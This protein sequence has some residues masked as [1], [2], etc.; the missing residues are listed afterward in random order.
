MA[1]GK[2][3]EMIREGMGHALAVPDTRNGTARSEMR[4]KMKMIVSPSCPRWGPGRILAGTFSR[5][6]GG[7]S[8]LARTP[9]PPLLAP[10]HR[11]VLLKGKVHC[12]RHVQ[13]F[14]HTHPPTHTPI[15]H[16]HTPHA[17]RPTP[18]HQPAAKQTRGDSCELLGLFTDPMITDMFESVQGHRRGRLP[19]P[20]FV[21]FVSFSA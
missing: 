20:H 14:T 21:G 18:T 10:C 19:S 13:A 5:G 4:M 6:W 17:P 11:D 3:G 12:S 7:G 9:S 15:T 8:S 1:Y 16:P 2:Q